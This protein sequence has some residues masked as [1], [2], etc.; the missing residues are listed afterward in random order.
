VDLTLV[1][2][3]WR[4]A[5]HSVSLTAHDVG[6]WLYLLRIDEPVIRGLGPACADVFFDVCSRVDADL[7]RTS[8]SSGGIMMS[9]VWPMT[10]LGWFQYAG[11][12]K[13]V[14]WTNNAALEATAF[15]FL[16]SPCGV[17]LCLGQDPLER[18]IDANARAVAV[19]DLLGCNLE[20]L[21]Q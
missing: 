15:R 13:A 1:A 4:D 21:F 10:S 17:G 8:R 19:A 7:A 11:A 2:E 6:A 5:R 9:P 14:G 18:G 16:R 12:T 20:Y 3:E